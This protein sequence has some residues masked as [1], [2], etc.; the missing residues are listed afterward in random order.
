MKIWI[1]IAFS[2]FICTLSNAQDT[3]FEWEKKS[4]KWNGEVTVLEDKETWIFI[5]DNNPNG[6][7]I[8]QQLP[9]EYKKEGLKVSFSGWRGIIPPNFRM[10]GTPLKL[11]CI[12]MSTA[13][14]KKF[15]LKKTKY[16]FQ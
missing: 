12:C 14:Q 4:E 6:R 11:T 15:N 9:E 3:Q 16:V 8:S 5:P 13:E 1:T 10:I 7:F 2:I